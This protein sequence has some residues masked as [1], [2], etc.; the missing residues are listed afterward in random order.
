MATGTRPRNG[1]RATRTDPLLA[2]RTR[3]PRPRFPALARPR[4]DALLTSAVR[5][6]VTLVRAIAGAGKTT[7]CA[8]WAAAA[9]VDVAWLSVDPGD[10][11]CAAVRAALVR[12]GAPWVSALPAAC[13]PE[14]G[15]P[16]A[17]GPEAGGLAAG[18][19]AAGGQTAGRPEAG[20]LEP[21][22]PE[23]AFVSGVAGAVAGARRPV[24]LVLDGVDVLDAARLAPL[25]LL[26]EHAPGPLRFVL[27][28][29]RR[30]ALRLARHRVSGDLATVDG[31]ALDCDLGELAAYLTLCGVEGDARELMARTGGWFAAARLW[32]AR[33]DLP[34]ELAEYIDDEILRDR[35]D[36][37]AFL[38]RLSVLD[39]FPE[40]LAAELTGHPYA[41]ALLATLTADGLLLPEGPWLRCRPPLAAALSRPPY[42]V[43]P[44]TRDALLRTASTWYAT[45]ASPLEAL[46]AALRTTD[47]RT[48][49][50]V[51]LTTTLPAILSAGPAQVESVLDHA[52]P[53]SSAARALTHATTRLFAGD[54][55]SATHHLTQAR[56]STNPLIQVKCAALSLV[57]PP[58]DA[59]SPD[60]PSSSAS[61]P[62]SPSPSA[63][64]RDALSSDATPPD[65][66][67]PGAT[68][69]GVLSLDAPSPGGSPPSFPLPA[70]PTEAGPAM[71]G[72]QPGSMPD[73]TAGAWAPDRA[74][75]GTADARVAGAA[76][77]PGVAGAP[78]AAGS[79]IGGAVR[80]RAPGDVIA[81]VGAAD[82][83]YA[84]FAGVRRLRDGGFRGA[85]AAFR[86]AAELLTGVPELVVRARAWAALALCWQ[87]DLRD[88]ER[89]L[90]GCPDA[91]R[92][93]PL[94]LARAWILVERDDARAAAAALGEDE[95]TPVVVPGEPD[96]A[97]LGGIVR[98]RVCVAQGDLD[99]A[100][101][102]LTRLG[103]DLTGHLADL[104]DAVTIELAQRA[105]DTAQAREL[106]GRLPDGAA[107]RV[108]RGR[109]L[110]QADEPEA[111]LDA[112]TA[113][114]DPADTSLG[115]AQRAGA[116][117]VAAAA[118]ARLRA[119][120]DAARLLA[121]ALALAAA[122]T[123]YGAL[124]SCG[125]PLRALV[126]TMKPADPEHDRVRRE[127]LRRFD[128]RPVVPHHATVDEEPLTRAELSVLR[129]LSSHMTNTEIAESLVVSVNT[130]KT[131]LRSIY[132]KFGVST[133]RDAIRA[134]DRLGL[135]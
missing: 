31:R 107:H 132:R 56:E 16:E 80:V 114:I 1:A 14:A 24:V 125:Q 128:L 75:P 52:P 32:P 65:A 2:A 96:P 106:A 74:G 89:Q 113:L 9:P 119:A 22:G 38:A 129:F 64:P 87:G 105:G 69:P 120:E 84:Y 35:P 118:H 99:A 26:I 135:L 30:P 15:G 91:G 6:R 29:R 133:R 88:A 21:G 13:A 86:S 102:L 18:G 4:V 61:S 7:A 110:L 8:S 127:L 116:L 5:S 117:A 28:G 134:A 3:V 103:P 19:L 131:H 67:S 70:A 23:A 51:L 82:G 104:R 101:A 37:A 57:L 50:P 122:E 54:P 68:P 76:G 45:H 60:A 73:R 94:D 27:T 63:P 81:G 92:A 42:G 115:P 44:A 49:D 95:T 124:L 12:T 130:V 39:R 40:D 121:D 111:A 55:E 109:I 36:D 97:A 93:W 20:G 90:A 108:V 43:H 66:M 100:R 79:V 11:L 47:P 126:T 59:L 41:S 78:G 46:R 33:R 17:G 77:A 25:E 53:L 48:A 123:A 83:E 71:G 58:M 98:A 85:A 62:D 34:L 112:V 10:D 72:A